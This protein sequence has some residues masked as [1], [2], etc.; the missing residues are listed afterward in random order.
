MSTLDIACS[1]RKGVFCVAKLNKHTNLGRYVLGFQLGRGT[2][3]FIG[4][5]TW[6]MPSISDLYPR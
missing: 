3:K 4:G 2:E 1:V 5:R 6:H